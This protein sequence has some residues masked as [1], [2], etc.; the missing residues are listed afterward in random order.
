P[1]A[2]LHR[3]RQSPLPGL[4]PAALR[5]RPDRRPSAADRRCGA[6]LR[7]MARVELEHVDKPFPDGTHAVAD[8]TLGIEEGELFVLVGPSGCGKSTVLRL[9][10]GLETATAGTLRIGGR[11]C[12]R[13]R[14]PA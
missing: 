4:P 13:L 11:G 2:A 14:P 3:A 10:A 5:G 7:L 9:V 1:D 6:L 8:A 12:D